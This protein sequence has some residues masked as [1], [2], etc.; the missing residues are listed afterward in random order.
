MARGTRIVVG[1][2]PRGVFEECT[3]S[4]TPKPGTIM[5][6][7]P[8]VAPIG[9]RFKYR[10]SSVTAG[11]ARMIVILCE[12]RLQGKTFNDAYVDGSRGFLYFPLPGE[13]INLLMSAQAGTG[14]ADAF[15]IG[16]LI[17]ISAAGLGN[18]N[19]SYAA[20]PFVVQEHIVETPAQTP[21]LVWTKR[22]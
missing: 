12:D 18:P 13:D 16:D 4:G 5:E 8:G 6:M 3:V 19:A 9:G 10:A 15:R 21:T 14:S 7:V 2:P 22:T 1:T 17:G 20:T 11:T